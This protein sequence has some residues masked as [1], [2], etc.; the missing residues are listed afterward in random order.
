[1]VTLQHVTKSFPLGGGRELPV[2]DIPHLELP[3]ERSTVL[4]G[5]SGSGKT[6]LL[7]IIAGVTAPTAGR[8]TIGD[9]DI[10]ALPEAARDRF[11]AERIGY[12]FQSFNL[13]AALSALENVALPMIFARTISRRRQREQAREL[14]EIGRAHV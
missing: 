6:T 5:R 2:L 7:N 10:A 4:K 13:L 12:V 9:T 14:L 11:R 3:A 1:M 8:I